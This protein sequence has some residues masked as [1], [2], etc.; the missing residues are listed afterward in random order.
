MLLPI[1]FPPL[2]VGVLFFL[3]RVSSLDIIFGACLKTWNV[4]S[5]V[6]Y[7]FGTFGESCSNPP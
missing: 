5:F 4:S 6:I 3:K 7:S 2:A 1:I